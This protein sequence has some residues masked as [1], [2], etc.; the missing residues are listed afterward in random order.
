MTQL[1]LHGRADLHMH[2]TASDGTMTVE[3]LLDHVAQM[4]TLDVIA[5]TD[6]D[7]ID[8]SLWAYERR[9]R[10]GFD[11]V[12]GVEVSS[13]DGHILAL[14]VTQNIPAG[15]SLNETAQA[16]HEAGGTAIIA[17][18]CHYYMPDHTR[19]ALRHMRHPHLL[20][21]AGIDAVEA[22]NAGVFIAGVNVLARRLAT[23]AGLPMV[24]GSDAHTLGAI[25]TGQTH[26]AGRSAADLRASIATGQTHAEGTTW[27]RREYRL[28]IR[29]M[30][31][32]RGRCNGGIFAPIEEY[33]QNTERLTG[34][35][36]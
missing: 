30:F 33:G 29:D 32:R 25:G 36:S 26:F 21:E 4:G 5:I 27:P 12:P 22:H 11:I 2:T 31:A 19:A 13:A 16:I 15:L 7:R 10:Y 1:L 24:G 8:A 9:H 34:A 3:E 18:P 35:E 6:H 14:W 17:H 28:F 20:A 23:A